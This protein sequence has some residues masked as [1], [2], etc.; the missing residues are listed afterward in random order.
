VPHQSSHP[1]VLHDVKAKWVLYD[2]YGLA[3]ESRL[4]EVLAIRALVKAAVSLDLSDRAV[5]TAADRLVRLGQ[6]SVTRVGRP[7]LYQLTPRGRTLIQD[8]RRR[9]FSPYEADWDG[10][11]CVVGLSVPEAEREVRDRMRI[12]LSWLGFGSPSTGFY[13]SPRDHYDEVRRLTEDLGA[14]AYVHMY[15]S[16]IVLPAD[17]QDLVA[18]AWST[19]ETI[20]ERYAR[21]V[22][23]FSYHHRR[24]SAMLRARELSASEAFRMRIILENEFRKCLF[25]DPHLPQSLMPPSWQGPKARELFVA[26]Q[27][28]VTPLAQEYFAQLC[29]D[30]MDRIPR[31][32]ASVKPARLPVRAELTNVRRR[33]PR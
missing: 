22:D 7:S 26:Y 4:G 30:A 19:L 2:L 8:A 24:T 14:S 27:A 21:F 13:L 31:P 3:L 10:K 1:L 16:E 28:L 20:N 18:R 12:R 11:W 23:Q 25:D 15:R 29:Q 6:L 9:M 5:R 17:L 33:A 32:G